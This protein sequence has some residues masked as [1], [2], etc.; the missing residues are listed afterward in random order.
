MVLKQPIMR[1]IRRLAF[2]HLFQQPVDGDWRLPNRWPDPP[3]FTAPSVPGKTMA[4]PA[5][6]P[7]LTR[8]TPDQE[9]PRDDPG[10]HHVT[11]LTQPRTRFGAPREC[12]DRL[13]CP[14]A[15]RD[16]KTHLS[17]STA[18]RALWESPEVTPRRL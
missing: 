1:V 13:D 8:V 15:P 12:E 4:T 6:S 9:G 17:V 11:T 5:I 16:E 7:G 10:G 3:L 18:T 14:G 2:Q